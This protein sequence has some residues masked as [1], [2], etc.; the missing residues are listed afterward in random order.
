MH[1][2]FK[3]LIYKRVVETII[4]SQVKTTLENEKKDRFRDNY[5]QLQ[6]VMTIGIP[7]SEE[8]TDQKR[9]RMNETFS[10]E[11]LLHQ[12]LQEP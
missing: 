3:T 8:C 5:E 4:N 11:I 9:E 6:T 12:S 10:A 7:I 2:A 1:K